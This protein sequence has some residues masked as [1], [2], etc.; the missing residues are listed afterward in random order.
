MPADV[1]TA[2]QIVQR[3]RTH[4]CHE[5]PLEHALEELEEIAIEAA[6]MRDGTID[7]FTLLVQHNVGEV[8][9]FIDD[10][11]KGNT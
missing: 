9:I 11:I 8:V 2:R 10:Q 1:I 7:R 4:T 6:G 3:D 5:D